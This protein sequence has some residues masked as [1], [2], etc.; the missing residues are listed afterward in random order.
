MTTAQAP[1]PLVQRWTNYI[2]ALNKH[3]EGHKQFAYAAAAEVRKRVKNLMPE[4]T[5]EA[6]RASVNRTADNVVKE[7]R[8]KET[9]YDR[10]T[11]Y[12]ATQGA[13][14]F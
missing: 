7:F 4:P 2:H 3:E 9:E 10:G 5:C 14:F 11:D 1:Q 8:R 12:G 6:L 13:R